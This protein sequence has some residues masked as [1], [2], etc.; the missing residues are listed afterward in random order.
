MMDE[1]VQKACN[2]YGALQAVK[3]KA[4]RIEVELND[5]TRQLTPPAMKVFLDHCDKIDARADEATL[6]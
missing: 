6:D 3:R 2:L 4:T 1:Q 5:T